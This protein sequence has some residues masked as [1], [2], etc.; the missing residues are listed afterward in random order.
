MEEKK[1]KSSALLRTYS[2]GNCY[3]KVTMIVIHAIKAGGGTMRYP[4]DIKLTDAQL[5]NVPGYGCISGFVWKTHK[6]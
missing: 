4:P 2:C 5:L 3:E 1:K 6:L